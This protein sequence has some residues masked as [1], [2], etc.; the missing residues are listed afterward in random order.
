MLDWRRD[1]REKI[2][3]FP[4]CIFMKFAGLAAVSIEAVIIAVVNTQAQTMT[5]SI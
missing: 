4:L 1:R 2:S 5:G 3:I